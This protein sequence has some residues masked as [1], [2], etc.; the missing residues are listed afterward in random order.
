MER[1]QKTDQKHLSIITKAGVSLEVWH[2][3]VFE[4]CWISVLRNFRA[5][6]LQRDTG[7]ANNI[8][9]FLA[10]FLWAIWWWYS[11]F[12]SKYLYF[13]H[14]F[15]I[16][17]TFRTKENISVFW[18]T[19]PLPETTSTLLKVSIRVPNSLRQWRP[20]QTRKHCC[21]SKNVSRAQ[22]MFLE[23]F[24]SI[25][26]SKTQI[27]CLQHMLRGGANEES[28]GKHWRN[29]DFQCVSSFAYPSN[30]SWRGRICVSE[31]KMFC[32]FPVCALIQHCEQHWLK[33]FL[34]Q[35]FLVCADLKSFLAAGLPQLDIQA[36]FSIWLVDY[37]LEPKVC[38]GI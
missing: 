12:S 26:A 3:K 28:L 15:F 38:F 8:Y 5:P 24:K 34:Q 21:R 36:T 25:F 4:K 14:F 35:C 31:A 16:A 19:V 23:N 17:E 20:A 1:S 2:S 22:K 33:M 9:I 18:T 6:Y 27:L 32:F 13:Q 30:I 10:Q 7:N 37:K 11:F 29:T